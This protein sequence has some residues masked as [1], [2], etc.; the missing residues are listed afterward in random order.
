MGIDP[1]EKQNQI[2][3]KSVINNVKSVSV[4]FLFLLK[5]Y[6]IKKYNLFLA[7][8]LNFKLYFYK[9]LKKQNILYQ[10]NDFLL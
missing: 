10:S 3:H 2:S 7:M 6:N 4:Y 5:L 9:K 1:S 8:F